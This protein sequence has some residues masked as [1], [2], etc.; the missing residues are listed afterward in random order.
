VKKHLRQY[1]VPLALAGLTLLGL[2]A[3][4]AALAAR[5]R[6][7]REALGARLGRLR[8]AL[9]RMIDQ[10]ERVARAPSA[11]RKIATAMAAAIVSAVAKR[12]A[13]GA[14]ARHATAVRGNPE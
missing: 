4:G 9:A 3:G 5:R 11:E 14:V 10:P 8:R 1:A 12:W 7:R 2:A 13:G 6:R